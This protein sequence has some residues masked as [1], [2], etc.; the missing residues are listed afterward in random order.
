VCPKAATTPHIA[1][2]PWFSSHPKEHVY[3]II[4]SPS[5]K[6]DI[7]LLEKVQRRFTKRLQGIQHLKYGVRLSRLGLHSLEL[8]RLHI[9]LFYCYST[10]SF[11]DWH[12]LDVHKY[13]TFTPSSVTRGHPHKLNKAQCENSKRRNFLTDRIV[14]VWNSL[15]ANVD[16]S[17]LPGSND[18]LSKSIF[19]S[20][21][22]V[23]SC[24]HLVRFWLQYYILLLCV[25]SLLCRVSVSC[26]F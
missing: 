15:P 2:V 8:R 17:S 24:S 12:D 16:F 26:M 5:L 3:S 23:M 14:N 19:H 6:I 1:Q 20:C 25:F 21:C 22:S 18:L 9:D 11:L 7:E 10:K 13:F 4:W